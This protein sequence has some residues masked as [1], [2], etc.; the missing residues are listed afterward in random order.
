MERYNKQFVDGEK[1]F[2][3]ELNEMVG[4][5]N[6]STNTKL[7][8]VGDDAATALMGKEWRTPTEAE[9]D[10]LIANCTQEI[11]H[12]GGYDYCLKFTS[13]KNNNS[14]VLPLHWIGLAGDMSFQSASIMCATKDV[15]YVSQ[16]ED[17]ELDVLVKASELFLDPEALP[18][19]KILAV[20]GANN[21]RGVT[22]NKSLGVDL[23][24]SVN[25]AEK[26]I[27]SEE[28]TEAGT[29]FAWGEIETKDEYLLENHKYII[30][31]GGYYKLIMSKYNED[32]GKNVLERGEEKAVGEIKF[33][34]NGGGIVLDSIKS[35]SRSYPIVNNIQI[36][37]QLFNSKVKYVDNNAVVDLALAC[38][39]I[40]GEDDYQEIELNDVKSTICYNQPLVRLRSNHDLSVITDIYKEN[41]DL[42]VGDILWVFPDF[43]L[44]IASGNPFIIRDSEY[45]AICYDGYSWIPLFNCQPIT[46][47]IEIS[48]NDKT[49]INR[50]NG[51]IN[52]TLPSI[53]SY[54][55]EL[56]SNFMSADGDSIVF[57]SSHYISVREGRRRRVNIFNETGHKLLFGTH[58]I[59]NNSVLCLISSKQ[60]D[61]KFY[62]V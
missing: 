54:D 53:G 31:V 18:G 19:I 6:Q 39:G 26:N 28:E 4:V 25:W 29:D 36:A 45:S 42:E 11:I 30:G 10:E 8:I 44:I 32:D 57:E 49:F 27:G 46:D 5:I 55:I 61:N 38:G 23:G 51:I 40:G 50:V 12:L 22:N 35:G 15:L 20:A 24:L 52:I 56:K 37:S 21:V 17:S 7:Q 13:N 47:P 16:S 60:D 48:Q 3:S 62:I 33:K 58:E 2:A 1:L 9:I 14:I 43:D 34:S 41:G 59:A